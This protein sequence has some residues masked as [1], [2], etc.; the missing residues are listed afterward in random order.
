M[1]ASPGRNS[2]R[3]AADLAYRQVVDQ[4]R[5]AVFFTEYGVPDTL[6]GRF[7]LICLHAFLYLHRLKAERPRSSEL[8]QSFFDRMFADFDHSLREIGVG[9]LS[10]GKH[11][12]RMARAFYGRVFAYE[13]GLAGDDTALDAALARNVFGTVRDVSAVPASALTAYVRRA[14][15]ELRGQSAADLLAGRIFFE[16]PSGLLPMANASRSAETRD[17][18]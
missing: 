8:C 10:V 18:R 9:D 15:M 11:V 16:T 14:V 7:E 2:A 5:E 12:K 1:I 3:D 17:G 13:A 4:A 6:D